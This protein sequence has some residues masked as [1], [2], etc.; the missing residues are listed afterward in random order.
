M[1]QEH[2]VDR[3]R[4]GLLPRKEK[5]TL[6]TPPEVR[7]RQVVANEGAGF[8]EVDGVVVVPFDAGGDGE[9]VRRR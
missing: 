6:D 1:E 8:D 3:L 7:H 5:D 9:D 2:R 4:T